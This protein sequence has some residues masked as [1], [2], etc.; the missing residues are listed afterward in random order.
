MLTLTD[1]EKLWTDVVP[2]GFGQLLADIPSYIDYLKREIYFQDYLD[3]FLRKKTYARIPIGGGLGV[4]V[5]DGKSNICVPV[6]YDYPW[7][8]KELMQ[9]R[10]IK[11]IMVGEAPPPTI[12]NTYFYNTYHLAN[13]PWL[14][15]P[16][17]AFGIGSA[18]P[19]KDK[20][21]KLANKCYILI[22]LFPFVYGY[23]TGIRTRFNRNCVS[24]Y[25]FNNYLCSSQ[26]AILV[27]NNLLC[28]EP[29]LAFSGPPTIHHF[30]AHLLA[31]G[32]I[33][34]PA[35]ITCRSVPNFFIPPVAPIPLTLPPNGILWPHGSLLSGV[36]ANP[37]HL[38]SVPFYRCCT[39]MVGGLWGPHEL[40]I[41]NAF[42]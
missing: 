41:R 38:T 33:T 42:F 31:I 35:P 26:L 3:L 9:E 2:N 10:C 11:Y 27:N 24:E 32:A 18:L 21:I 15:A 34:I 30:L 5:N 20:L 4:N 37:T 19:K 6:D 40:F 7:T 14:D 39:Y 17:A 22:D 16:V 12:S 1:Y 23:T 25:F 29:I 36:Y 13:T 28:N 8:D